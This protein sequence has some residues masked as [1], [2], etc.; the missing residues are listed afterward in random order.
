[1]AA[2]PSDPTCGGYNADRT[3]NGIILEDEM[4]SNFHVPSLTDQV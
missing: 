3:L 4:H 1:M 2:R